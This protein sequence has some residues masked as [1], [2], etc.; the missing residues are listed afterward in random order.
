MKEKIL[1]VDDSEDLRILL[2]RILQAAGY[3]VAEAANGES[4][5]DE[6]A[7]LRPDLVLLDIVMP[8]VSGYEVCE[9]LKRTDAVADVPVIFLSARSDAADKI[10]GLEIGGSD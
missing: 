7:G 5:L 8:G 3:E 9:T 1:I 10:K 6:V 2:R 4:A